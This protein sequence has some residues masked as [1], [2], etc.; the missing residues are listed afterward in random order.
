[1]DYSSLFSRPRTYFG[2]EKVWMA[3][4]EDVALFNQYRS[5]IQNHLLHSGIPESSQSPWIGLY[6]IG[7]K[8]DT[9]KAVIVVSCID[10]R[11]RKITRNT[12]RSCPHFQQGGALAQFKVISKATPPETISEPE[13]TMNVDELPRDLG[14]NITTEPSSLSGPSKTTTE[15]GSRDNSHPY[16]KLRLEKSHIEGSY[17][18][19]RVQALQ[20]S[21]DGVLQSQTA[22]AG[23]FLR[24]DG[25]IYQL[26]VEH[27]VNF[28]QK[29]IDT[30]QYTNDDWDDDDDDDNDD[31]KDDDDSYFDEDFAQWNIGAKLSSRRAESYIADSEINLSS[32]TPNSVF[33]SHTTQDT[34]DRAER[35]SNEWPDPAADVPVTVGATIV[36]DA[37]REI[38]VQDSSQNHGL[39]SSQQQHSDSFME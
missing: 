27:L 6:H 26:T 9:A 34:S 24:V 15:E 23:P 19:R 38:I 37:V 35:R 13:I 28:E 5:S 18:C 22:T 14:H 36:S 7:S 11:I 4:G 21:E 3:H 32:S 25:R 2:K 33:S 31:I 16:L 12:L 30:V 29:T 20:S 10:P 39:S 17:L 1:M 8:R